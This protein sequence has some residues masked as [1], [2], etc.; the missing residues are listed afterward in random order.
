MSLDITIN[1]LKIVGSPFFSWP[2]GHQSLR[3]KGRSSDREL[4]EH[5]GNSL[6]GSSFRETAQLYSR[7]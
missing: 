5:N 2:F 1:V 4:W 6:P 7:V 3:T